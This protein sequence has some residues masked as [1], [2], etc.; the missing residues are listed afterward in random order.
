MSAHHQCNVLVSCS[1]PMDRSNYDK[2]GAKMHDLVMHRLK[3]PVFT[4]LQ[5]Y[6]GRIPPPVDV[7]PNTVLREY[8]VPHLKRTQRRYD[9]IVLMGCNMLSWIFPGGERDIIAL[10]RALAPDGMVVVY[11]RAGDGVF[12]ERYWSNTL[13]AQ[14]LRLHPESLKEQQDVLTAFEKHFRPGRFRGVN[15]YLPIPS[16][17]DDESPP[18]ATAPQRRRR[19]LTAAL[20][21]GRAHAVRAALDARLL[22]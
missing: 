8:L 19:R 3:N 11:E 12:S 18:T 4:F 1:A 10:K 15:V 13:A 6:V 17:E 5:P 22:R 20:S 7:F 2:H 9:M 16:I 21:P 14:A